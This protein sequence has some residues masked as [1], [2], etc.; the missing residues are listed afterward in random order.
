ME[1]IFCSIDVLV[2]GVDYEVVVFGQDG[3]DDRFLQL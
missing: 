1:L 2:R 3:D